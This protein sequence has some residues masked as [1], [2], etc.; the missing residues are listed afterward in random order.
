MTLWTVRFR[1]NYE[2][3]QSFFFFFPQT[4]SVIAFTEQQIIEKKVA[5]E[6]FLLFLSFLLAEC[7]LWGCHS[8]LFDICTVAS[9]HTRTVSSSHFQSALTLLSILFVN[10]CLLTSVICICMPGAAAA[11]GWRIPP[12]SVQDSEDEGRRPIHWKGLRR[13]FC[14]SAYSNNSSLAILTTHPS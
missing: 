14:D 7:Y 12:W 13:T 9:F 10:E 8:C 4:Q 3:T 1:L 6:A 2:S 11:V 5:E